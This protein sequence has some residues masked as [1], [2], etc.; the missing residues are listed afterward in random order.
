LCQAWNSLSLRERAREREF[1]GYSDSLSP[2]LPLR[3][4]ETLSIRT[5]V[6]SVSSVAKNF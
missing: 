5:V 1:K 4:R 3:G 2:T 6:F